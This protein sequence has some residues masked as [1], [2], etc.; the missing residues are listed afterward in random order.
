MKKPIYHADTEMLIRKPVSE[1]FNAFIKPEYTTKFWFTHSSG[2][3]VEGETIE[4]TWEMYGHSVNVLVQEIV[5][6]K[7]I[8]IKW[9]EGLSGIVKWNFK[10]IGGKHTLVSISNAGFE[11]NTEEIIT[12]IADATGGFTLVLAGLKAY[13]EHGI[14]LNLIGDRFPEIPE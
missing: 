7:K 11:G 1:V 13:L 4:W 3:L 9:G 5:P 8:K 12:Q 6:N 10:D 2:P 14:Q